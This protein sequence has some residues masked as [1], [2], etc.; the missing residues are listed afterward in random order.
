MKKGQSKRLIVLIGILLAEIGLVWPEFLGDEGNPFLSRFV[1]E[2]LLGLLGVILTITL[3]SASNLH[4]A[5]NRLEEATGGKVPRTRQAL[6]RSA[7]TL[8][9]LFSAALGVVVV[10]PLIAQWTWSAPFA[11]YLALMIVVMNISVLVDLTHAIFK[12]PPTPNK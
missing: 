7:K 6:K 12:I 10:K 5:L 9:F 3:A 8:L 2:Q 4:L 11:N 1:S